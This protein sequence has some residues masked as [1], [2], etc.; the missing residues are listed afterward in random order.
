MFA[1]L[2]VILRSRVLV[3]YVGVLGLSDRAGGGEGASSCREGEGV[4]CVGEARTRHSGSGSAFLRVPHKTR[5]GQGFGRRV[6]RG[7]S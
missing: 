4:L 5:Q 7:G 1:T 2:C 3:I 6:P